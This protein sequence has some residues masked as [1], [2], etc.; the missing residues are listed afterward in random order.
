MHVVH[1]FGFAVKPYHAGVGEERTGRGADNEV[2]AGVPVGPG[3]SLHVGESGI[4]RGFDV[5]GDHVASCGAEGVG[6][7]PRVVAE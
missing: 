5:V 3:V 4:F 7:N 6:H 2:E 1:A